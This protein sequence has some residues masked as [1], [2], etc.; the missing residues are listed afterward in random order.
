MLRI[1]PFVLPVAKVV[2][3]GPYVRLCACVQ[4][5]V[6]AHVLSTGVTVSVRPGFGAGLTSSF[7]VAVSA[8]P[9]IGRLQ[10]DRSKR[11]NVQSVWFAS[12]LTWS[13][14]AVPKLLPAWLEST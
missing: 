2:V 10:L 1:A 3:A 6:C 8:P 13:V 11:M 9:V 4:V 12:G 14:V 7:K 5:S